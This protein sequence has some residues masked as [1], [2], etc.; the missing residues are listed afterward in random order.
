MCVVRMCGV[1]TLSG[2]EDSQCLSRIGLRERKRLERSLRTT[3]SVPCQKLAYLCCHWLC[4]KAEDVCRLDVA[5]A[6]TE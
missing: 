1:V 3:G 6:V 4:F 5:V 2:V